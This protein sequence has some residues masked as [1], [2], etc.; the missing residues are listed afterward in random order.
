MR[1]RFFPYCYSYKT[2]SDIISSMENP[3]PLPVISSRLP[4]TQVAE[5]VTGLQ[6]VMVNVYFISESDGDQTRWFLV[7]AGLGQCAGRIKKAAESLFGPGAKPSAIL[8]THGHFDHIGALATLAREW[9]VPVYAHPL[10][11]PYLTGQS[12]YPPPDPTVGG[13]ALAAMAGLY[14]KKPISLKTELLP[15][16]PDGSI[17]KLPGWRVIHTPG[18]TPG[19][20][21]FF[22]ESDRTLI[23]GDAFVTVKQE[24]MTDVLQQRQEL[25]GPPAYFTADWDAAQRSVAELA[26]LEPE[27]AAC[28]HGKP[29][30]GNEL[31][32]QLADLSA[33]F[34]EKAVP[35]QGRYVNQPAQ[36]DESGVTYVPPATG[37]KSWQVAGL[38]SLAGVGLIAGIRALRNR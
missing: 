19:H 12:S 18:H 30:R 35:R 38:V 28:G 7:D 4:T 37:L 16:M 20:V 10:E 5:G 14:P 6:I 25:H 32:T 21:S 22:R 13:G 17:S 15:Y 27:V 9:H 36:A 29:M 33:H 24:S 26:A 34:S 3:F 2:I 11:M 8:L 1:R 31:R 23:A